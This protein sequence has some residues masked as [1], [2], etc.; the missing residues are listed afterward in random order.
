[1]CRI[2]GLINP[3]QELQKNAVVQ[4]A[5]LADCGVVPTKDSP[6]G[7]KDGWGVVAYKN[8]VIKINEK[9]P[10]SAFQNQAFTNAALKELSPSI[11]ISH[12]RK[13][14]VGNNRMENTHPYTYDNFSFC[15]NGTVNDFER[16]PLEEKYLTLRKGTSDSEWIFYYLLEQ[17]EQSPQLPWGNIFKQFISTIR[18]FDYTACNALFSDGNVIFAIREANEKNEWV[19][20][21]NLCDSYYTLFIGRSTEQ[22]IKVI[23]S[24]KLELAGIT[25]SEIPNRT[26]IAVYAKTGRDETIVL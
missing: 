3:E 24:Q 22:K 16:F 21:E 4:F 19:K 5:A 23:C 17:H 10:E 2:L 6:P 7:H 18:T 8:G 26:I 25:W 11:L 13:A 12:L 1:M 15:H 14:S 20:K 9:K